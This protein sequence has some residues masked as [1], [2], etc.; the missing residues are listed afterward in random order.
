MSDTSLWKLLKQEICPCVCKN[1]SNDVSV[2]RKEMRW[3]TQFKNNKLNCT[4]GAN[5]CAHFY[6]QPQTGLILSLSL[7]DSIILKA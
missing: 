1:A 6:H 7:C 2:E 5:T 4:D 3:M